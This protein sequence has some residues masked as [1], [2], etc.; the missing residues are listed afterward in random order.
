MENVSPDPDL[1]A[2]KKEV[3]AAGYNGEKVV[4]LGAADVPRITAICQVGAD[5]LTKIGL[6]VDYVSLDWGTVVQRIYSKAPIAEGGWS[7]FGS[8][9]GGMDWDNP[10][11]NAALRGNGDKAWFGWPNNPKSESIRDAWLHATD[12]S[13]QKTLAGDMQR[14]AYVDA[15][16]MPLGLYNQPVA[17]RNDLTGMMKGLILFTGVKR[18]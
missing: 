4:F 10:A 1:A 2:L 3:M 11:G 14:Q 7:I 5:V 9:W 18:A 12:D 17:Y 13:V 15:P 6:N 8:M 16:C